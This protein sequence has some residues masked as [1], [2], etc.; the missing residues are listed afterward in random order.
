LFE[1]KG[2]SVTAVEVCYQYLTPPDENA[3]RALASARE[4]Y[5]IRALR[6]D[7]KNRSVRVEYDAS[8]LSEEVVESLL[9]RAGL[10]L[11]GKLALI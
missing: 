6:F 1:A 3:L 9:R 8:R 7:E 4:V 10:E 5:G 2:N 11:S